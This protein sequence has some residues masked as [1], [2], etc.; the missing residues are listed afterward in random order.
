[1]NEEQR[2]LA[3]KIKWLLFLRVVIL[4]FF[5]GATALFHFFKGGDPSLFRSL[6][7]PLIAAYIISIS[8]A[9][10][11]PWIRNLGFFA[12][13][14]VDF[15]VL[16]ITGIVFITGD[17]DSPFP[18]LYNLAIINS[19]ILLFYW[20]AFITAGFSSLCYGGLLLWSH[21]LWSGTVV[22]TAGQLPMDLTLNVPTFFIIAFLSGFLARKVFEAERLLVEKQKEYLDLEALK[23]ALLQGVGSGVAITD[24][25]GHINYFNGQAQALT[26]LQEGTVKGKKLSDIFPGLTYNFD[27]SQEGK[28]VVVDDFSFTDSQGRNKHLRLT[29]APLSDP[30]DKAIGF[31]SIFED[32]TKQ[33]ELE[34]KIRLEAEM[35]KARE[36]D[37]TDDKREEKSS[38]F[39][40]A[41]VV[42]QG[43]GVGKIYNLVQKVAATDTSILISGE[44]GTGKELVARAIHFNGPRRD[45]PFV[46]VNCGAIPENLIESELFG[47][48]R[49]AFTGA[50]SDHDGLFKRADG[51]SIFLDEVGEL[52]LHL[53]V[54]LLRVLQEKSF[55]PVG[56]SKQIK[57]DVRVISASNKD[58]RKELEKG[59]FRED[60]FYR[61]N[62]VQMTLPPLRNRKEDIP[63]LTNFFIQKFAHALN[64][65]VEEISSE[66]LMYLMNYSYQG[67]IRE[68][69]NIIEHAVAVTNKN[70]LTE[71]DLPPQIKGVSITEEVKLFERTAPGGPDL[72][73]NKGMSLDDELETHEKCLLLGALKRSSGV[74]KKAAELL[75]I[76]YRSFRHR[77]EKYGLLNMKN[78]QLGEEAAE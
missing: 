68:L 3:R 2:E 11:L 52:P 37:L 22:S 17:I 75:G 23:E 27:G 48:V 28:R 51:G 25:N 77:L 36:R 62:V 21:Y 13:A 34:Q 58:L 18:F 33:R 40:F 70:I 43:G 47:H 6:Q 4:T 71:E 55:T 76:N 7:V 10:I 15:D 12:H 39:R 14:Q 57:V 78:Q 9:L 63:E 59:R 67:N 73:F 8:S 50:V 74:Q 32:V 64:K 30:T 31:V 20:G 24:I 42:G 53:Q 65:Q 35:R 61:L 69:E 41:G 60:L 46:A 44:S 72:F 45:R 5:L 29:L 1:M 26:S 66:A 54:K 16:L 38:S 49:G 56:G 19:A